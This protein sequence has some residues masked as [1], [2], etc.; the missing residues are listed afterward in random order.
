MSVYEFWNIQDATINGKDIFGVRDYT[1]DIAGEVFEITAGFADF[2]L[3]GP[4][5]GELVILIG[6]RDKEGSPF[7]VRVAHQ[8][9]NFGIAKLETTYDRGTVITYRCKLDVASADIGFKPITKQGN[10]KS[11][12]G[13]LIL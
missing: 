8:V 4:I 6:S 9:E 11:L 1:W 7:L 13:T 2:S 10:K 12:R 5:N 3:A